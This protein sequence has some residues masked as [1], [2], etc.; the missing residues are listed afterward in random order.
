MRDALKIIFSFH[1]LSKSIISG[2][3]NKHDA[4]ESKLKKNRKHQA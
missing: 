1:I 3:E 2:K 4:S